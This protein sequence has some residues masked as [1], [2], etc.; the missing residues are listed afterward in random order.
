MRTH[1][2]VSIFAYCLY[3][4]N[5]HLDLVGAVSLLVCIPPHYNIPYLSSYPW[6]ILVLIATLILKDRQ[7]PNDERS[8]PEEKIISDIYFYHYYYYHHHPQ[9]IS[10]S[11]LLHLH[12]CCSLH[13]LLGLPA[14]CLPVGMYSYTKLGMYVSFILNERYVHLRL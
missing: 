10:H 5:S 13:L 7:R 14:F 1:N 4:Y 12:R 8:S 6:V 11:G 3:C 2:N 9:G